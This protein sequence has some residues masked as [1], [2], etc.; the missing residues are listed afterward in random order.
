LVK[1]QGTEV[2]YL[3]GTGFDDTRTW[4]FYC[5]K[6]NN[7]GSWTTIEVP[8]CWE[9][10]G[11][12]AYHYG[13]VP[14]DERL[15]EEGH[16]RYRFTADKSWKGQHVEL[17]FEGVMTDARVLI[18]GKQAGEIHQGAFYPFSYDISD[19]LKY[20]KENLLEVHVKKFSD[21]MTVN[22][23][24]RKADYWIF[25]G[26][27][28]PVYLEIKPRAHISNVAINALANGNL[29]ADVFVEG[30][31]KGQ[32]VELVILDGDHSES[33]RFSSGTIA[34]EG[35]IRMEGKIPGPLTWTPEYPN[36]YAARFELKDEKGR[37]VH[38]HTERFGFRTVE[39]KEEDGIYVNGER[40]KFKGVCRHTFHPEHGR[41]SSKDLSI[42]VVNL[43]KDMNMNAVRM[44][45]Y[46]PDRHF[47]DVCDSL[48]LFV[49][50][51]LAGW[52]APSY[53]SVVGRK[54][55]KAMIRRDVNH[56]SI[57]L[58]DNANEGGWNTAYD[59][60]FTE[61]DIQRREVIHPWAVHEKTNTA[62]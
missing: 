10:E 6:G 12:G 19:R 18:N 59:E 4:E 23:A 57:V 28:R 35:R 62:H 3:S 40:I 14:F 51:E 42:E 20:G 48:G 56:P 31:K 24:E 49:L 5:S 15:K 61:L 8:S 27:F 16:Y 32:R 43:M 55:L 52:Q 37:I 11:F 53:D 44:S 7:S 34:D 33:W 30:I 41:T 36:L 58:W 60:D 46:P 26:I 17:F 38:S 2:L 25:G 13:H 22:E 29:E 45:H 21:N 54:L 47:L 39:I 1:G 9:Q 50:N